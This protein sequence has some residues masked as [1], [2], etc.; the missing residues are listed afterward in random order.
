MNIWAIQFGFYPP[1]IFVGG[2]TSSM[3][4]CGQEQHSTL[5]LHMAEEEEA[6][7]E[8]EAHVE[9]EAPKKLDRLSSEDDSEEKGAP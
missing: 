9:E 1:H 2:I 7:M 5:A 8:E 6:H 3:N 4:I